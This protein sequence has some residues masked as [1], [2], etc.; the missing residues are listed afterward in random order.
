MHY[1]RWRKYGEVGPPVAIIDMTGRR[2]AVFR[3][4]SVTE[5]NDPVL[6]RDWCSVHYQRW[7]YSG[8]TDP[9]DVIYLAHLPLAEQIR[10]GSKPDAATGC[11]TWTRALYPNGYGHLNV[12]GR[13]RLA[14]RVAYESLV[15]PIPDGLTLDHECHSRALRSGD[16]TPGSCRH[17]ACVNPEHLAPVT[18]AVNN[19]RK[20]K[21][22]PGI[23]PYQATSG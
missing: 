2:V 13:D 21:R 20:L 12:N 19:S 18:M 15:G 22:H 17:R 1:A 6:A 4:C 11:W 7:A 16:C 5:C 14:H 3:P 23:R 10:R 9:T 8:S